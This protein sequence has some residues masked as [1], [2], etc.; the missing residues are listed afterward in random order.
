MPAVLVLQPDH[1]LANSEQRCSVHHSVLSPPFRGFDTTPPGT[2]FLSVPTGPVGT[3]APLTIRMRISLQ[4]PLRKGCGK[5]I[6]SSLLRLPQ[7]GLLHFGL[8]Q[9][10]WWVRLFLLQL[11]CFSSRSLHKKVGFFPERCP[12]TPKELSASSSPLGAF[13]PQAF[14]EIN[15]TKLS[16]KA[17]T[18]R[19]GN[20]LNLWPVL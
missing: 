16:I 20:N 14:D 6:N 8:S 3:E 12:S 17:K 1:L 11:Q 19:T 5:E 9:A 4:N 10:C 2:L 18:N 7:G 15:D 13:Y